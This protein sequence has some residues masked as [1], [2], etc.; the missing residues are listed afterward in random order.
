MD[1]QAVAGEM[2]DGQVT[3]HL[4]N[5]TE[6]DKTMLILTAKCVGTPENY[7]VQEITE[8]E[9]AV[10]KGTGGREL[11]LPADKGEASF[12]KIIVLDSDTHR[13]VM[14]VPAVVQ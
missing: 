1:Y 13:P 5:T 4:V 11:K 12:V 2:K 10:A 6:E 3:L 14:Y 9:E 8:R 7:M